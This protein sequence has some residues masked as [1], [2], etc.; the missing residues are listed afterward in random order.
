MSS[1]QKIYPKSNPS[2]EWNDKAWFHVDLDAFYAA[3]EQL[4]H[5]EYRGKPVIVGSLPG[6]RGVVSTCSYEAREYGVHSAMPINQAYA[7]CPD[8]IYVLPRMTRYSEKSKE[9]MAIFKDFSP[10]IIQISVDEAFINMSGTMKLFGSPINTAKTLRKMVEAKTGLTISLGLSTNKYVSKIASA[11]QKPNGLTIVYP[12]EEKS[13]MTSLELKELWGVG[14]KTRQRMAEYNIT[15]VAQLQELPIPLL[16]RL[17]GNA[18]GD[19]IHTAVQGNDPGIYTGETKSHSISAER[20]FGEDT[21]DRD[22][23]E[24]TLLH[25]AN[26]IMFRLLDETGSS[27]TL[28]FKIRFADFSSQS[29]QRSAQHNFTSVDEIYQEALD[30]LNK[31][32]NGREQVRLIGLGFQNVQFSSNI[33]QQELFEDP[34]EKKSKVEKAVLSIRQK[35]DTKIIKKARLMDHSESYDRF[36]SE[37]EEEDHKDSEN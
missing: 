22:V 1:R 18:G 3:V 11:H 7:K 6:Y 30:L 12:G 34:F 19:F 31:K 23:L 5:P 15:S 17:F 28:Y 2:S 10:E 27:K 16:K 37:V 20:T 29:I 36:K 33:E 9:V 25:I 21:N 8:G 24:Q 26:T 35:Y 13:F 4:D 32:W 14:K